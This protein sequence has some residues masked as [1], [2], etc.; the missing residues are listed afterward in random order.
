MYISGTRVTFESR[1][2]QFGTGQSE[3]TQFLNEGN[4]YL[5]GSYSRQLATKWER[6]ARMQKF[7]FSTL[8]GALVSGQFLPTPP[9]PTLDEVSYNISTQ[10]F[11]F[12]YG[13][14]LEY[15]S[16]HMYVSSTNAYNGAFGV[17]MT[18]VQYDGEWF[19]DVPTTPG[20][21]PNGEGTYYYYLQAYG[22]AGYNNN[23]VRSNIYGPISVVF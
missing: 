22:A 7:R 17:D 2:H 1:L 4:T 8:P 5:T 11:A 20:L 10:S 23:T 6:E 13:I 3:L 18:P 14:P 16:I 12:F 21:A 9:A 19:T 15:S